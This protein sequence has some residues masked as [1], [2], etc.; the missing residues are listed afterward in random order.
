MQQRQAGRLGAWLLDRRHM[1]VFGLLGM[2][3]YV[4]AFYLLLNLRS[5]VN[6]DYSRTLFAALAFGLLGATF[7]IGTLATAPTQSRLSS[8]SAQG[9]NVS[10]PRVIAWGILVP[11]VA[12]CGLVWF[13][14]HDDFD[15]ALIFAFVAIALNLVGQMGAL[16]LR[17]RQ[18][19]PTPHVVKEI[20]R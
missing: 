18:A 16:A 12:E 4:I 17:T 19:T 8:I 1:F 14:L 3:A 9:S 13:A 20:A 6:V 10:L 11:I 2:C 5:P 7:N 15:H